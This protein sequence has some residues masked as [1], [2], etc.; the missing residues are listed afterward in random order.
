M[1]Q[2]LVHPNHSGPA[3][4]SFLVDYQLFIP[5]FAVSPSLSLQVGQSPGQTRAFRTTGCPFSHRL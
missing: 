2:L 1:K 3:E 4:D 5:D